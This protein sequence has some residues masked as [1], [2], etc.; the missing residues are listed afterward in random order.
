[1][2]YKYALESVGYHFRFWIQFTIAGTLARS[3]LP[4]ALVRG[5][6]KKYFLLEDPED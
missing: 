6:P 1:M 4:E 3:W 2:K 5:T